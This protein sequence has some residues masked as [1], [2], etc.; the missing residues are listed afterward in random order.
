MRWINT[1]P[2]F[3]VLEGTKMVIKYENSQFSV[4]Y[5]DT[6]I[7]VVSNLALAKQDAISKWNDMVEMGLEQ[8]VPE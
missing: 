4:H 1:G 8:E 7:R 3:L 2:G 5:G 6:L